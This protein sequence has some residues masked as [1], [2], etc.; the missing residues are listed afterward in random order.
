MDI[1]LSEI[2]AALSLDVTEGQLQV[3]DVGEALSTER[4]YRAAFADAA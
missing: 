1:R 3:A 4:R 2:V